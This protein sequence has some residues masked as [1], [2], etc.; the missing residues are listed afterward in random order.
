MLDDLNP[1][2]Q[3]SRYAWASVEEVVRVLQGLGGETSDSV[4]CME[5]AGAHGLEKDLVHKQLHQNDGLTFM[6]PEKGKWKIPARE[7]DL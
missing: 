6:R 3:S 5:I 1:K 2:K 7:H 4:L